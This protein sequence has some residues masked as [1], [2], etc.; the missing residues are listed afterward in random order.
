M[1]FGTSA[2]ATRG[3]CAVA[4]VFLVLGAMLSHRIEP[5]IRVQ[6]ITLAGKVAALKFV[7]DGP[8]PHPVALLGHGFS[9]SK[10]NMFRFAEALAHAG[11]VCYSIDFPGHGASPENFSAEAIGQAPAEVARAVGWVNVFVGHSM[12]GGAGGVAVREHGFR[13]RLFI[14]LGANPQWDTNS[15]KPELL[16]LAGRFEEFVPPSRLKARTD[17]RLVL[18]P[19]CDHVLEPWDPY[20]VNAG[21]EAACAAVGKTPPAP[22]KAW[23]WR[24]GGLLLCIL[25]AI[26]LIFYT[27]VTPGLAPIRAV[28]IPAI[29]IATIVLTMSTYGGVAPQLRR[30]LFQLAIVIITW[31]ALAGLARWRIPRWSLPAL[32]GLISLS[33][34]IITIIMGRDGHLHL[35][36]AFLLGVITTFFLLAAT[37]VGWFVARR[38]T[39]RQGNVAV[40]ILAGYLIG[41]WMPRF[42]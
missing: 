32:S 13:P 34:L 14:A 4:A 35:W 20:L 33:C 17:A 36:L 31:L 19:W 38:G 8:G 12:G 9:G 24:A 25:G 1:T 42:I 2:G 28:L 10:E 15:D 16:L 41:Q 39:N 27:Q 26:G 7:P 40:A 6:P 23:I 5:G 3:V 11:F 37:L 29:I 21:V 22:G 18:S 30:I